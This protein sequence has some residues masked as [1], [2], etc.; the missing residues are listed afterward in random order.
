MK[1]CLIVKEEEEEKEKGEECGGGGSGEGKY[2][3]SFND[4]TN[5]HIRQTF[6]KKKVLKLLVQKASV[7]K[8]FYFG[9]FKTCK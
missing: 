9:T 6:L 8:C 2:I 1:D 4:E 5:F 7:V 3:H